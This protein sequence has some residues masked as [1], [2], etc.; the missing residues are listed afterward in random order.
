MPKKNLDRVNEWGRQTPDGNT[1][2]L[3]ESVATKIGWTTPEGRSREQEKFDTQLR[4]F[5]L[6]PSP[7]TD[8]KWYTR[9]R[10][11]AFTEPVQII[12]GTSAEFET[13]PKDEVEAPAPEQDGIEQLQAIIAQANEKTE[14]Q[15]I[16]I[17]ADPKVD[18]SDVEPAAETQVLPAGPVPPASHAP[19]PPVGGQ[20]ASWPPATTA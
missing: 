6:A 13:E 10:Y 20:S 18:T 16:Q 14:T 5:G 4:Q 15:A 8:L 1:H 7:A 9:V 17:I 11:I 19:I 3:T 2:W 12:E